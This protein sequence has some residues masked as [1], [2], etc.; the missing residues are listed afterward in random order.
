MQK[1]R[2]KIVL[3][4]SMAGFMDI[5]GAAEVVHKTP[6]EQLQFNVEGMLAGSAKIVKIED[7]VYAVDLVHSYTKEH[8][9]A[10]DNPTFQWI[11]GR[12][13]ID[14]VK[15]KYGPRDPYIPFFADLLPDY[16]E[17]AERLLALLKLTE[18]PDDFAQIKS[19]YDQ[20]RQYQ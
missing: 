16:Q 9:D 2:I 14:G 15:K 6:L 18:E 10:L 3:F 13:D 1:I 11:V 8:P 20:A 4:L 7:I 5:Q 17:A 12:I 19:A